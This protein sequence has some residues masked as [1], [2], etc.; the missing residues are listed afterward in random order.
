MTEPYENLF[1]KCIRLGMERRAAMPKDV[2]GL[3]DRNLTSG[4]KR[5][6][7]TYVNDRNQLQKLR[8][9]DP[10]IYRGSPFIG[11]P[12]NVAT[13]ES[14]LDE[15]EVEQSTDDMPVELSLSESAVVAG[16]EEEPESPEDEADSEVDEEVEVSDDEAE[17]DGEGA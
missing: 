17:S 4:S 11:N 5:L 16:H 7:G 9:S 12:L 8:R 13:I 14:E 3:Y 6:N 10:D 2:A 15:P 1:Q